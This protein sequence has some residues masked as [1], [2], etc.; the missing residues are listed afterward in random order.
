MPLGRLPRPRKVVLRFGR[1]MSVAELVADGDLDRRGRLRLATR[2]IMD[3]IAELGG[4]ES[5]E[6]ALERMGSPSATGT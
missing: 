2:R 3:A 5:R 6:A 4:V 1:P